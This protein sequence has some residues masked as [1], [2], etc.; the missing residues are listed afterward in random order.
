MRDPGSGTRGIGTWDRGGSGIRDRQYGGLGWGIRDQGPGGSGTWDRGGWDPGSGSG[1]GGMGV[2][3]GGSR[4]R[5]PGDQE[6]GI[7]GDL[8]S[9]IG[10]MGVCDGGSGIRDPGIGTWDRGRW[11]PGSGSGSRG[12]SG[13]LG[14]E[15]RIWG[16][17]SGI[18]GPGGIRMTGR[19]GRGGGGAPGA[20]GS[21]RAGRAGPGRAIRGTRH[22]GTSP[23]R[24]ARPAALTH[25]L[26]GPGRRAPSRHGPHG[27]QQQQQ[28]QV[29]A[30]RHAPLPAAAHRA[31]SPAPTP[32]PA[33]SRSERERARRLGHAPQPGHAY[34]LRGPAPRSYSSTHGRPCPIA[35]PHSPSDHAPFLL[36]PA[37]VPPRPELFCLGSGLCQATP[38]FFVSAQA[39]PLV[40]LCS[41]PGS[42]RRRS[43]P[44]LA[45]PPVCFAPPFP[46][47]PR[48]LLP[49]FAPSPGITAKAGLCWLGM[50]LGK[51]G[52]R[53]D[54]GR[55][56]GRRDGKE[57]VCVQRN[58]RK[59]GRGK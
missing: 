36:C 26:L 3:D 16:A 5:D 11:D 40:L 38:S 52:S 56:E 28:Q 10:G 17:R 46:F 35:P 12:G 20:N 54:K 25:L 30:P 27:R 39:P 4:I 45:T 32:T 29:E 1:I 2:W 41:A 51:E 6:P 49:S 31:E 33:P 7:A 8:G 48:P 53:R 43:G 57:S 19:V 15:T 42:A 50:G 58:Q 14:S 21:E 34:C 59:E 37:P 22:S 23:G 9:G 47:W 24:T 18:A 13:I 55:R 44:H